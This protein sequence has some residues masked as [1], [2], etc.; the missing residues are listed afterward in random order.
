MCRGVRWTG[1]S[2]QMGQTLLR[3]IYSRICSYVH[4]YA[5]IAEVVGKRER[6]NDL[7]VQKYKR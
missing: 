6:V 5:L 1:Y 2:K 3:P 4:P 7:A